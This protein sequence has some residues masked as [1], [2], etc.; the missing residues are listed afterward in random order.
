MADLLDELGGAAVGTLAEVDADA[1][2]E[3]IT[4]AWT[5]RAQER[6]RLGAARR[7]LAERAAHNLDLWQ[8]D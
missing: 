3:G 8:A 5:G 2:A 4:R 1:V 6:A 7:R